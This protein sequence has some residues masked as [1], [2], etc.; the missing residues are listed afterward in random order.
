M[1]Q[2]LLSVEQAA[3]RLGVH[4]KTILRYIHDAQLRATRVGKAYRIL[5]TD[6]DA[7]AGV[8]TAPAGAPARA[9]CI[10]EIPGLSVQEAGRVASA[11]QALLA[12]RGPDR[13]PLWLDT[14][15][16]T[17]HRQLKLVL[18]GPPG[19]AGTVLGFLDTYLDR[20]T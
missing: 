3:M 7:F 5:P 9:T 11:L 15:F 4:R 20:R 17:E 19:A 12:G 14:A 10:V 1:T 13:Q 18:I 16:D 6:L 2:T 8:A